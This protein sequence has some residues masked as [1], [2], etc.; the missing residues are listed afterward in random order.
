MND[1][2]SKALQQTGYRPLLSFVVRWPRAGEAAP[3]SRS[4]R[5]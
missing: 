1:L 5:T 3:E 4:T 2:S